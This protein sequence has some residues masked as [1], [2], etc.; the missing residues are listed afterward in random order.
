[1]LVRQLQLFIDNDGL[2]RCGGRIH[3]A[4]LTQL[5]KFPYSLPSKHPFT[6]LIVYTAHVK[7]Y[8]SGVGSTVTALHQSYWIPTVRQYVKS[9]LRRCVVCRKHSGRPY[10]APDPAP[11]PKERMQDTCP[12]SV[13]GVDFTGAFYVYHR[14]EEARYIIIIWLFTCATSRAIHLEVVTDLSAV[15]FLLAFRRFAGH[16][17]APQL[18]ISDNATTFQSATEELKTLSSSEEVRI[19]L[20]CEG[21]TWKF[22]PKRLQGLEAFGST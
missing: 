11:L 12:F 19:V 3:N 17:S 13:T 18:M 16:W 5:A 8:H 10:T 2:L 7:L 9:L 22:M 6:T 21:V 20:N 4:S 15:T 14:G 1:M